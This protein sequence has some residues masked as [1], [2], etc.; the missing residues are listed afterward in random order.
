M[1]DFARRIFAEINRL[2]EENGGEPLRWSD[3]LADCASEQS[4]RKGE[5]RFPGHLDPERGD[6]ADRLQA[7]GIGWARCGENIFM[8]RGWD[9]PVNFAVVS[10][11]YSPSHQANLLNPAFT[12]TG[13]GLGQ[14]AD[15]SWFV[16][17]IFL[18]PPPIAHTRHI[19]APV[20]K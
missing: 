7:A 14:G 6:V 4:M 9:D 20:H 5:L 13:V 17:Q 11:W 15:Q 1:G 2:R 18:E 16:T 10:W 8:E 19:I 12:V 3:A